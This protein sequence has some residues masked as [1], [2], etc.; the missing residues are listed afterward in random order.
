MS[1]ARRTLGNTSERVSAIGLGCMTMS[2]VFDQAVDDDQSVETLNRALDLGINFWDTANIYGGGH[3]EQLISRVLKHRRKEVFLCTKFGCYFDM[4]KQQLGV[5]GKPEVVKKACQESLERLGTDY[6]D[7][8]YLHRVDPEVPIEETVAAMAELVKEGKVRYLGISECSAETLRRAHKV[9]PIAAV[10]MEYSPWSTDIEKN[11]MLDTCRELGV[12]VVT[13]SPLGQGFLTGTIKSPQDLDPNDFR[14]NQPR[15]QEENF[16]HNLKL[17]EK[18][19]EIAKKKNC[20]AAQLCIAWAL[21][22]VCHSL[23]AFLAKL[24]AET[25]SLQDD[26]IIPIPGTRRIS[27]LEENSEAA[28]VKLNQFEL[29]EIRQYID[30]SKLSGERAFSHLL[31][32]SGY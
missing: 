27:R 13:Y 1:F 29:D 21:A 23:P 24:W 9:H 18:F 17:A 6:I 20:T 32:M 14:H 11:G 22:Q 19:Q 31:Q 7:L 30:N 26:L 25:L 3:N 12:S 4:Q 8:Y 2:P 5:S 15:F 16:Q 10:Q 28:N